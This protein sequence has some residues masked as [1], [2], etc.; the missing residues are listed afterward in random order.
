MKKSFQFNAVFNSALKNSHLG[1]VKYLVEGLELT[2]VKKTH[3][4]KTN[5]FVYPLWIILIKVK[6]RKFKR[7]VNSNDLMTKVE[8]NDNDNLYSNASIIIFFYIKLHF[9]RVVGDKRQKV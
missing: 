1:V 3:H 8:F 2:P 9:F 4:K 7:K 5:W 6:K